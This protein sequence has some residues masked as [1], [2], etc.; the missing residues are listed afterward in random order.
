M[1]IQKKDKS[2]TLSPP[3]A[4][5]V[6]ISASKKDSLT[7]LATGHARRC[8][9]E[10]KMLSIGCR[11]KKRKSVVTSDS[12][13]ALGSTDK[14]NRLIDLNSLIRMIEGNTVC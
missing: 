10:V 13:N 5:K 14:G 8:S 4:V 11:E 2:S 9:K 7:S 6:K 1:T 3:L 12:N